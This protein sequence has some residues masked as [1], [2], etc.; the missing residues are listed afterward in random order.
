[1]KKKWLIGVSSILGLLLV[2]IVLFHTYEQ[3]NSHTDTEEV[4]S[5]NTKK[6][7]FK[8]TRLPFICMAMVLVLARVQG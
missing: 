3:K 6:A 8:A 1:M 5:G 7:H 4:N 2:T